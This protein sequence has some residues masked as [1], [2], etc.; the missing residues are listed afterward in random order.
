MTFE[1]LLERA[2]TPG[3]SRLEQFS[4]EDPEFTQNEQALDFFAR[5]A[6]TTRFGLISNR[7]SPRRFG[8]ITDYI[9]R[10]RIEGD[11]RD[12]DMVPEDMQPEEI[13]R[14]LTDPLHFLFD[15]NVEQVFTTPGTVRIIDL[16]N[17]MGNYIGG[18]PLIF[19]LD[20]PTSS[21]AVGSNYNSVVKVYPDE[22]QTAKEAEVL[23]VLDQ[24]AALKGRVQRISP[25]FDVADLE[26]RLEGFDFLPDEFEG[27]MKNAERGYTSYQN[28][29][30][31]LTEKVTKKREGH[32]PNCKRQAL[33]KLAEEPE[34]ARMFVGE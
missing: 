7:M 34:Q 17:A 25:R 23:Q 19:E 27:I 10:I 26:K 18:I 9:G 29:H 21:F 16:C 33:L 6:N 14:R 31:I 1:I 2:L 13:A 11:S 22:E 24:F 28:L 8:E 4:T 32:K 30:M 20:C 5:S 3:A 15:H 12:W